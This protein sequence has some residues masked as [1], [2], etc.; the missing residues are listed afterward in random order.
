MNLLILD[1][2]SG[3]VDALHYKGTI[4]TLWLIVPKSC[5]CHSDAE[6]NASIWTCECDPNG[7]PKVTSDGHNLSCFNACNCT[8]VVCHVYRRD[9][10][11]IQSPMISSDKE[12][13]HSSTTNLI[14]HRT[15]SVP[16]TKV[17]ITYYRMLSEGLFVVWEPKR[18]LSWKYY[19]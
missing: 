12:T 18:N 15:F 17:A 14:S 5:D 9:K 2:T 7:F 11:P 8:W 19:Y 16:E 13:S 10:G 6:E 3:N 1:Q 4:Y